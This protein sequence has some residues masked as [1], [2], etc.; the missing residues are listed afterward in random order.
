MTFR[1]KARLR[2][3]G[4]IASVIVIGVAIFALAEFATGTQ[5]FLVETDNPSSMSPTLNYGGVAVLYR[6]GFSSIGPGTLIAFHDPRGN[7]VI[8]VHR[9]VKV[10]NCGDVTCFVTKGDNNKTN[11]DDDPW[12]V[13]QGDYIGSVMLVVPYAGYISPALWGFGGYY[14]L[15]PVSFVGIAFVL[16]DLDHIKSQKRKNGSADQ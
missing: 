16:W 3:A 9:V 4:L 15:L 10:V 8:V 5:P 11:P 6:A 2:P 14:A 7:P 12:N 1:I 13:T